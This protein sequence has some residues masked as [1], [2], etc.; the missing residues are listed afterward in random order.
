[1][2]VLKIKE[3]VIVT[4]ILTNLHVYAFTQYVTARHCAKCHD[5]GMNRQTLSF[6]FI[7]GDSQ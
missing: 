3:N 2:K 7:G 1:M 5:S 4:Q 6:Y